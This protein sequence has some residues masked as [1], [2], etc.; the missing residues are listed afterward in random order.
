MEMD[1]IRISDLVVSG[2]IGINADERVNKQDIRVNATLW[3]DTTVAATSDDIEDAVNYRTIT[4][5]I[6]AHIEAGE[7]MLVERLVGEIADICLGVPRVQQAEVTVEKPGALRHARSVG[8]TIT[9][10]RVD[11]GT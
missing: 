1:R 8:I 9:R 6:I 7:P 10:S 3:V 5:T 2:I 11:D 4:K